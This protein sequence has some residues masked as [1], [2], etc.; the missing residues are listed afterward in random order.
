[1]LKRLIAAV[2]VSS[3]P[4]GTAMAEGMKINFDRTGAGLSDI[5]KQARETAVPDAQNDEAGMK[6]LTV[7]VFVNAKNNLEKYGLKDVN[8]META[9]SDNN[10]NIV[11]ELGRIK[12]YDSSDGNWTGSKRYL[13]TP[14]NNMSKIT[15]QVQM[16]IPKSD[17]GDWNHLVDFVKWSKD[18]YPAK[19]YLLIVWNHG[20]GWARGG[21]EEEVWIKG[22]SYDDETGNHITTPQL[23][24]ALAAM[25]QVDVY[26][27]DACL[28]QMAEVGYEIA[29]ANKS[30][31]IIVGSE[32]TEPG[33]GYPYDSILAAVKQ[34]SS[35]SSAELGKI[36]T[37]KYIEFYKANG[38]GATQSAINARSLLTL[39]DSLGE[40][41]AMVMSAD[42]KDLIKS[43][44]SR[45]QAFYYYTSKDVRHFIQ[46]ITEGTRVPGLAAKGREI[47]AYL[48]KNVSVAN[49]IYGD[50]YK[51]ASGLA[52]Y[53]PSSYNT[54][55]DELA[56]AQDGAWDDFAK[57]AGNI[58]YTLSRT[59]LDLNYLH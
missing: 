1:M 56:W 2:A 9:G 10:L 27:S 59:G 44:K 32:E 36:I 40:W 19:K 23:G 37:E 11:V 28:M 45:A 38:T 54:A 39:K 57:W 29:K 8:E 48:D 17:M 41:T 55:Y 14:D 58:T 21:S 12:G 18:T 42:E 3:I 33:D 4:L 16:E 35:A 34:N 46:L 20:S 53:V 24:Q 47:M 13:V 43:A 22:I 49:G 30:I 51:D 52:V 31:E 25:G 7:M 6:E 26:A 5:I 50:K 15:S